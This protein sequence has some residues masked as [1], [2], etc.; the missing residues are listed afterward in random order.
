MNNSVIYSKERTLSC[1][2]LKFKI[3]NIPVL[4]AE[5]LSIYQKYTILLLKNGIIASTKKELTETISIA[6]NIKK[7]FISD[8]IE[9]L[10]SLNY[11]K[12]NSETKTFL[13]SDSYK[14]ISDSNDITIM[15]ANTNKQFAEFKDLYYIEPFNK[16]VSSKFFENDAMTLRRTTRKLQSSLYD[17]INAIVKKDDHFK[18]INNIVKNAFEKEEFILGNDFSYTLADEFETYELTLKA[19]F[20][21][22]YNG[23]ISKLTDIN[24]NSVV[25]IPKEIISDAKEKFNIDDKLPRFIELKETYYQAI[26]NNTTEIE[27]ITSKYSGDLIEVELLKS[28]INVSKS[29]LKQNQKELEQSNPEDNIKEYRDKE[30]TTELLKEHILQKET[31]LERHQTD[32]EKTK[33]EKAEII[34]NG[35]QILSLGVN[36]VHPLVTKIAKKYKNDSKLGRKVIKIC[37]QLDYALSASECESFGELEDRMQLVKDINKQTIKTILDY[38]LQKKAE[39]LVYYYDTQNYLGVAKILK[40]KKV[41]TDTFNYMKI[42]HN[43]VNPYGHISDNTIGK[44]NKKEID[45]FK[46]LNKKE[47]EK[48]IMSSINFFNEIELSP[49]DLKNLENEL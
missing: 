23:E 30:I 34:K 3:E 35:E 6:L 29:K 36:K 38:L 9:V 46:K 7:S 27:K 1:D 8:F 19:I 33:K 28:D 25:E 4:V 13:L 5:K 47:R 32:L 22:E 26:E 49:K 40:E 31:K 21:Y 11:L 12:W 20:F 41:N 44:N 45:N 42:F 17:D 2:V 16:I 48:I 14:I 15:K 24:Y 37:A 39:S 10:S 18:S 43:I